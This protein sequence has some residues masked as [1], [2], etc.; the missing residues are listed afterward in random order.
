MATRTPLEASIS[1]LRSLFTSAERKLL[2]SSTGKKLA[3]ASERQAKDLLRQCRTLRDKWR[4]LVGAQA[5]TVKRGSKRA[6]GS[7]VVAAT[8]TNERSRQKHSVFNDV[9][10]HIET[11]LA[12]LTG[13]S[14]VGRSTAAKPAAKKPAAKK[15]SAARVAAKKTSAAKATGASGN[16]ATAAKARSI[17]RKAR[18]AGAIKA[19]EASSASGLRTTTAKQRKATAALKAER[20]KLKGV[21]TRRAGHAKVQGGRSQARRDGRNAQR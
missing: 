10:A 12:G 15:A 1:K 6:A 16:T 4:D 21:T 14:T 11:H 20:L 9:V 2:D 18:Q 7:R 13:E 5:R 8:P 19:L 17:S 3:A